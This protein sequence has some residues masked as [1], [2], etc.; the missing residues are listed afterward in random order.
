[1]TLP[2]DDVDRRV[3]QPRST[4]L[5]KRNTLLLLVTP[6]L[7]L[8]LASSR[9]WVTGR[10][11]DPVMGQATV[12]VSGSQAA[13]GVVALAVVALAAL[14][15]VL[16]GGPRIRRLSAVL[17]TLAALGATA[18][19]ALVVI[20]P[21]TVLS[22]QAAEQLG[23]TGA[24]G[25]AAA[26]SP[27]SWLAVTLAAVLSVAGALA[28]VA[29]GRWPGLSSRFDRPEVAEGADHRGARRSPWDELS[30]GH[31]PTARP[32]ELPN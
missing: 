4:L 28:T 6:T 7:L 12:S 24:I 19:S 30:E 2:A 3:P 14:V 9:T 32:D 1:M 29:V 18:L 26:L 10:T 27:W 16:T 22:R 5:T 25:S 11:S 15:A 8:L 17:L 13:P 20:D 23:R 31:D 21:A